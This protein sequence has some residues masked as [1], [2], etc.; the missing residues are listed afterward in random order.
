MDLSGV[1]LQLKVWGESDLQEFPWFEQPAES[2]ANHAE[3]LLTRLGALGETGPTILGI[4]MSRLPVSP[5]LARLLIEGHRREIPDRIAT[6]A[7]LL[8]ERN[9]FRPSHQGRAGQSRHD[10]KAT[11]TG[12]SDVLDLLDA[13][14]AAMSGPPLI[15]PISATSIGGA[16]KNI[17]RIAGQ[18]RDLMDSQLSNAPFDHGDEDQKVLIALLAAYPDRLAKRR[19]AGKPHALMVGGRGVQLAPTSVVRDADLFLCVDVDD[20]S[21]NARVRLA[22][23]V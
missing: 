1:F 15:R 14:E 20:K 17:E 10:V 3:R 9:P 5:R 13:F 7:A 4:S 6:L 23:G 16:G 11:H 12:R 8:S 21:T 19:Q 18:L 22:S 2:S